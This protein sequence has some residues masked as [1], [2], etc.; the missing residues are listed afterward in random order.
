[1]KEKLGWIKSDKTDR[2]NVSEQDFEKAIK[3]GHGIR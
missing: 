3:N 1:M 2:D